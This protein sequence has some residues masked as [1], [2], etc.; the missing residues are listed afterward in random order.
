MTVGA[1]PTLVLYII[2]LMAAATWSTAFFL[3][4]AVKTLRARSGLDCSSNFWFLLGIAPFLAGLAV[5]CASFS[6]AVLKGLS[7]IPDHCEFHPHHP[8]FCWI[9]MD[10]LLPEGVLFWLVLGGSTGVFLYSALNAARAIVGMNHLLRTAEGTIDRDGFFIVPSRLPAAF[11]AGIIRPRPYLTSTAAQ[12]LN[13]RERGIVAAHEREHVRRRDPL[14]L[15]LLRIAGSLFP[16][17]KSIEEKWK[18]AT[19]VECDSAS[20]RTGARPEE[21]SLTIVK[22]A[23]AVGSE[24]SAPALAY[25]VGTESDL[26]QRI[27]SLLS[28]VQPREQ[29]IAWIPLVLLA[30]TLTSIGLSRAH[31]ALETVLGKLIG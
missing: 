21:V 3:W 14:K 15:L 13:S 18:G 20:L 7:L 1:I 17:F 24:A 16:G 25:A 30:L 27:G 28:G 5:G 10:T 2:A 11:V 9:H 31:H 4:P 19:E 22:L 8:H 29:T 23:R 6:S 26:K 12:L